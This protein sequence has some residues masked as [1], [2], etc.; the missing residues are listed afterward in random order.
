MCI[1]CINRVKL[2]I[3][4][5][6]NQKGGE[7]GRVL[8]MVKIAV[9]FPYNMFK[10]NCAL[11]WTRTNDHAH[12]EWK[13][14]R[15]LV[16]LFFFLIWIMHLMCTASS[17]LVSITFACNY[18][19]PIQMKYRMS[20]NQTDFPKRSVIGVVCVI[21]RS[22]SKWR[23]IAAIIFSMHSICCCRCFCCD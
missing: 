11:I 14:A 19:F 2:N 23:L 5:A 15:W 13:L 1:S 17:V 4:K 20:K 18:I 12:K 21:E 8:L 10:I 6:S 3:Y 22:F 9:I 7:T 16:F